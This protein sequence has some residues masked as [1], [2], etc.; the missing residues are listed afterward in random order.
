MIQWLV[1]GH[2]DHNIA[3]AIEA[4]WPGQDIGSLLAEV[5]SR[6]K[7]SG[8]ISPE[9]L[10]GW[11]FECRKELYRNLVDIGDHSAAARVLNEIERAAK[12]SPLI[13][14]AKLWSIAPQ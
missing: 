13:E 5:I 3:D 11:L 4:M 7:R 6:I 2:H 8:S 1:A 9:Y 10:R 12:S 14:G